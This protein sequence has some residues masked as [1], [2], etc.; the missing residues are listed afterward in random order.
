MPEHLNSHGWRCA[1]HLPVM[2]LFEAMADGRCTVPAR[3]KDAT[4][5]ASLNPAVAVC[6]TPSIGVETHTIVLS[7]KPKLTR[8]HCPAAV[9]PASVRRPGPPV[10]AMWGLQRDPPSTW[11]CHGR[12]ASAGNALSVTVQRSNMYEPWRLRPAYLP[13]TFV[14]GGDMARDAYTSVSLFEPLSAWGVSWPP[15][16]FAG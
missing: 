16:S 2:D 5:L 10:V 6:E 9:L 15:A 13:P 3:W 11:S 8:L 7:L 14:R 12:T 1:W 4:C